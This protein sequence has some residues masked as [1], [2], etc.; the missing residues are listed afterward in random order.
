M[1]ILKS[2]GAVL[3]G[4]VFILITH[5]GTD[6]VLEGAGV[7]PKGNLFV[8]TGLILIVI[9]YRAVWSF[10][11]CYLTARLAP[12]NPMKHAIILGSIG[13]V[14]SSVGAVVAADLGPP[15]YAWTLAAIS[16]PVAWLGGKMHV[17]RMSRRQNS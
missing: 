6:A 5:T 17:W 7:L 3:A 12:R 10:I 11:G 2:I 1:T 16:L 9:A 13:L 8:P 14:V 15:W 4:L